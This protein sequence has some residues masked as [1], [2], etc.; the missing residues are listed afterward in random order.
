MTAEWPLMLLGA[1]L[2]V[3]LVFTWPRDDPHAPPSASRW[4]RR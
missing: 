4:W 2:G 3:A 1:A